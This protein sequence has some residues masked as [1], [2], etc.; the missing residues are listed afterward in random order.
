M[1]KKYLDEF[2]KSSFIL[3]LAMNFFAFLNYF[4]HFVSARLLEPV[5]YGILATL[6]S[7]VYIFNVPNEIIQTIVSRYSTK[8]NLKKDDGK[9]KDLLIKS[10]KIF[11]IIGSLCFL[12]FVIFSPMIGDFLSIDKKLL[13]LTGVTIIAYFLVPI[14]RGVLQGTKK[15]NSLG[16]TYLSE[17]FIKVGLVVLLI[18]IGWSVYGAMSAIILSILISFAFSFIF[19]KKILKIRR[20]KER[21]KGIY[22]YS[23]P[24]LISISSLMIILG[25]DII[26]AKRFFQEEIVGQYAVISMLSRIIFFGT[27]PITKAVFPLMS[28][29]FD[30]KKDSRGVLRKS[31]FITLLISLCILL[32]YF[33]IPKTTITI[34]FGRQY[35]SVANLLIYCSIATTL[36]SLTNIF[37]LYNLSI[38]REKRNYFIIFFVLSQIVLLFL[39]HSTLFQFILVYIINNL[40]LFLTMMLISLRR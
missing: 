5:N 15:F 11:S 19:L 20:K 27:W 36:L 10:I 3:F 28:E 18:L 9:I 26:L 22:S 39:F 30:E 38:N 40:I 17:G 13:M 16:I 34:L 29:K 7:I 4:F 35:I 1:F 12:I 8:F 33:L 24:V 25:M 21:I 23:F 2:V 32:L 14:T 37:V 31:F 6:M